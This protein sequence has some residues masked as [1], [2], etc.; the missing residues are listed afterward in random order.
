M[1]VQKLTLTNV[2]QFKDRIFSFHPGFN[3]LVGENGTG[4]TT[5]LNSLQTLLASSKHDRQKF[6]LSE[7]DIQLHSNHL[8]ISAEFGGEN[9]SKIQIANYSRIFGYRAKR[10]GSHQL[11][12]LISYGANEAICANLTS[13]RIKMIDGREFSETNSGE[14]WLYK[15]MIE[16]GTIRSSRENFGTSD[17]I[18]DLT[19]RI[20][21][22][23][24][25]RFHDFQWS[26]EP[27]S[28]TI[29]RWNTHSS[30][31]KLG[32]RKTFQNAI[33]R[34][35]QEA[36]N[37]LSGFDIPSVVIDSEGFIEVGEKK[38]AVI[39]PFREILEK[40]N[41]DQ[42]VTKQYLDS[43]AEVRLTPM[44]RVIGKSG[45]GLLLA[46]LS[47][48]EQRLFSLFVDIARQL[49]I[50][51][52]N[53]YYFSKAPAVVL[54]D[55]IDVHLHPKW[56]RMIAPALEELFPTCQ[57][58]A[59]THSPFVVQSLQEYQVQHLNERILGSF[60]D[61]GIE[62]ITVKVLGIRDPS[63][64]PRYLEMVTAA[65]KYLADLADIDESD[66]Q[67]VAK[68]KDQLDKISHQYARNPAYQAFMELRRDST[69][70]TQE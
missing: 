5:L 3:I 68:L 20:L 57:F 10:T 56:Q 30:D 42:Y 41:A 66:A 48:G 34:H 45:D 31:R 22:N 43:S 36:N 24:S 50:A 58:I 25:N 59:T 49:S 44:I 9:V 18:R 28:C 15:K 26:F 39:P 60:T 33:I 35:L 67:A 69:L 40:L 38:L 61:R 13:R 17:Y 8:K 65:K 64:S 32:F 54:I 1:Y 27:Y 21:K 55:E 46:Q 29:P 4:K 23:F 19:L 12:F 14:R 63:V 11:P 6:A 62:E 47:D 16:S 51:E 37:P 52:P 7:D 2:R 53:N 70:G